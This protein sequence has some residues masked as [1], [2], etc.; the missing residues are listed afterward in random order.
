MVKYNFL[1]PNIY[2]GNRNKLRTKWHPELAHEIGVFHNFDAE[3]ELVAL[4]SEQIAAEVDR[5]VLH[6]IR[7]RYQLPFPLVRRVFSQTLSQEIVNVQ[8]MAAPRGIMFFV[9]N[10]LITKK[11]FKFL[12]GYEKF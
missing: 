7:S 10:T 8:P 12:R 1:R 6:E 11:I 5:Q 9:G 3:A 4:L 2:F